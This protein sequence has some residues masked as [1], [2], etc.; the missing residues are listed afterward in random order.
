MQ[1]THNCPDVT[2]PLEAQPSTIEAATRDTQRDMTESFSAPE[3]PSATQEDASLSGDNDSVMDIDSDSS[4]ETGDSGDII[5]SSA[6][7][8]TNDG[9][10]SNAENGPNA[11][12]AIPLPPAIPNGSNEGHE[13]G[14]LNDDRSDYAS[15]PLVAETE[16]QP[17]AD[18]DVPMQISDAEDE[19][20]GYEPM[21]A[22]ISSTDKIQIAEGEDG[23]V[24]SRPLSRRS[25]LIEEQVPDEDPYEPSPA[26]A[27]TTAAETVPEAK[28]DEVQLRSSHEPRLLTVEQAE[29]RS[30]LSE[31]DLLSYQ[32]PLRYFHAYRFHPKYLDDVSGGLKSMTYSSRIDISRPICPFV[33]DGG[34]CPNGSGCEFQHFD[35]MVLSGM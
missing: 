25:S 13:V 6:N 21:P 16:D 30:S 31:K 34:R 24:K 4:S 11:A 33:V 5:T 29:S 22:Q 9:A 15:A 8:A 3:Q 2:T 27:S 7:I 12:Q 18:A 19:D 23:E 20:E 26:Q 17:S 1:L 32:S 28:I 35:N 10:Q 14:S